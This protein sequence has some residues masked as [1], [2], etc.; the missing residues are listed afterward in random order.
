MTI[1][2]S[3]YWLVGHRVVRFCPLCE[4]N[5]PFFNVY[6]KE[7]KMNFLCSCC[8]KTGIIFDYNGVVK[9]YTMHPKFFW[10]KFKDKQANNFFLHNGENLL[11]N[12]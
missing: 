4:Q 11:L 7:Y 10:E 1:K 8:K 3:F 12:P 5:Q 6:E 2:F 9:N